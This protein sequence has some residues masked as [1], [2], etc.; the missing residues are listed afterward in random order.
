MEGHMQLSPD[1]EAWHKRA[2]L[3]GHS[4]APLVMPVGAALF[5]ERHKFSIALS[6]TTNA[7]QLASTLGQA[8]DLQYLDKAFF[9][10]TIFGLAAK[11]KSRRRIF[12]IDFGSEA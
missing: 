1:R 2:K 7:I 6:M 3:D 9:F 10:S 4:R 5:T 8:E 12:R 11:R